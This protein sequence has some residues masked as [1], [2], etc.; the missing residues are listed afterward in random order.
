MNKL[1]DLRKATLKKRIENAH[2][3]SQIKKEEE[4]SAPVLEK[5]LQEPGVRKE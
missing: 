4:K 3:K 5:K 1:K 2:I